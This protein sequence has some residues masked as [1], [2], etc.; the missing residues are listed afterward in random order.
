VSSPENTKPHIVV[1]AYS[2]VGHDCLKL[3]IER[4]CDVVTVFTHQDNPNENQWFPSVARLAQEHNIPVEM[5]DKITRASHEQQLRDVLRPDLIF[6][7]YYRNLLPT[8]V[9][10]LAP[11]GAFN[12]HGSYLPKYRGRAPVNWA[13]LHG[14]T[15]IGAT[16]HHMVKAPDA[17]DIVD[18]EKVAIGPDEPAIDVQRRVS[19]AGLNVLNR[20]LDNLLAGTAPRT[21]QDESQATY[22][23][24]RR[25]EDGRINWR[26]PAR[27]IHNLVRAVTH[28]Y[29]GAFCDEL[30]PGHRI[31]L[32]RTRVRDDLSGPAG[33]IL[34]KTPF[35]VAAAEGAVEVLEM[36]TEPR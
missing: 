15:E 2:E 27:A 33:E 32:W 19:Q 20:Q 34:S 12:L 14:A 7:F 4:G 24:G 16:L 8:W 18:Q 21:P 3:L 36:T 9:L 25:P 13:V 23:G 10:E 11:L 28:P 22:Y 6:S 17:G 1:F 30:R 5:P 35:V 31:F 29:P 26:Q